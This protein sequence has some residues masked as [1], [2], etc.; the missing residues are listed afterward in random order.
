MFDAISRP[1]SPF[2][3]LALPRKVG[4]FDVDEAA[5]ASRFVFRGRPDA[6]G[7]MFPLPLPHEPCRSR[8][9]GGYAALWLGPDEWLLIAPLG[10][11]I[12]LAGSPACCVDVSHRNC[13][14]VIGGPRAARLLNA[15]CLLDLDVSA[16]PQGMVMRTLFGKAEIVLW[17]TAADTFQVDLWRSFTPYVTGLLIE[18]SRDLD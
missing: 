15:G 12:A 6:L 2:E 9:E 7:G 1:R 13:G 18:A 10:T 16:F 3:G 14:L 17:R 5:P 11:R 8:N 4:A